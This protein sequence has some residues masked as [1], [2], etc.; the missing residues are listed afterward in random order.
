MGL[1]TK[2][3][4]L[5]TGADDGLPGAPTPSPSPSER[6]GFWVGLWR[7]AAP[8]LAGVKLA[9][10]AVALLDAAAT[11]GLLGAGA[12]EVSRALAAQ[13]GRGAAPGTAAIALA[14]LVLLDDGGKRAMSIAQKALRL[15]MRPLLNERHR[16]G[17]AVGIDVGMTRGAV[18]GRSEKQKE[19]EAWLERQQ[20]AG[21][22]WLTDD[23]P[24]G[25]PRE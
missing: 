20:E 24:P 25:Q 7:L 4:E 3:S 12:A 16:T 14:A 11:S 13:I 21:A 17:M 9:L 8:G 2:I 10:A 5:L 18:A 23:P 19:W 22:T 1:A 15:V 6:R